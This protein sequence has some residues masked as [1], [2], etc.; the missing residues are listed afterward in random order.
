M[1]NAFLSR[2]EAVI[3][4]PPNDASPYDPLTFE[5]FGLTILERCLRALEKGGVEH[6]TILAKENTAGLKDILGKSAPWKMGFSFVENKNLKTV[7]QS[8]HLLPPTNGL[9]VL[10]EP[11]VLDPRLIEKLVETG[12][13]QSPQAVSTI[14]HLLVYLGPDLLKSTL[15]SQL[16][17]GENTL[18]KTFVTRPTGFPFLCGRVTEQADVKRIERFLVHNLTKPN[19]GWVSRHL[20]RPVSTHF[21]RM[22]AHTSVTPNQV[23]LALVL[24]SLATGYIL[25]QGEYWGFLIGGAM[26]HLTS[27]LDGVDGEL[28]RLK[29][30]S[31][32]YGKWL[33]FMCDNL[34]YLAAL[35]GFLVGLF[36]DGV[37]PFEKIASITALS[38]TLCMMCSIILY[39]KRFNKDGKLLTVAYGFREGS[40]LFHRLMQ[41]AEMLGKRE[42]FALIFFALS[43]F[44]KLEW[45][46]VY[47]CLVAA[48]VLLFSFEAHARAKRVQQETFESTG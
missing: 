30:K 4:L 13:L 46:L 24:P 27:V 44:G 36:R 28:A 42:W 3:M 43:I 17:S 7:L 37:S 48:G 38:L 34:A 47:V 22:L 5:I 26:F 31:S 29:F 14:N 18:S 39:Y 23:T 1:Q 12:L 11:L 10:S 20:N 32:L 2:L 15:S 21:S 33:D 45:A 8:F 35:I 40:S 16:L 41:Y 25:A 9:L 19:D 6:T